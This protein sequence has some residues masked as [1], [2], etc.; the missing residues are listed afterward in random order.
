MY[1]RK[2]EISLVVINRKKHLRTFGEEGFKELNIAKK[3]TC[4]S[5]RLKKLGDLLSGFFPLCFFC[6]I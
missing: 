4:I 6:K 5:Y 3:L 1:V 2:K